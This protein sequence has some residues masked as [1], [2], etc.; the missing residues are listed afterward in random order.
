MKIIASR[1]FADPDDTVRKL[2][3]I[4]KATPAMQDGGIYIERINGPFIYQHKGTTAE[5]KPRPDLAIAKDW[6]WL[7]GRWM[8]SSH[9]GRNSLRCAYA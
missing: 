8:R 2:M 6:L 9:T 7:H 1:P 5:Y 4:A 3:G